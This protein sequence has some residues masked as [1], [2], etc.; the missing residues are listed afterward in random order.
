[1]IDFYVTKDADIYINMQGCFHGILQDYS[2]FA[3]EPQMNN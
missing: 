2:E 3:P 1:M